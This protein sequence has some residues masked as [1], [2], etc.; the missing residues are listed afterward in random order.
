MS[1]DNSPWPWSIKECSTVVKL[2]W[3]SWTCFGQCRQPRTA[4]QTERHDVT[5][6]SNTTNTQVNINYMPLQLWIWSRLCSNAVHMHPETVQRYVLT[7]PWG[8][9]C[10]LPA[11]RVSSLV[12]STETSI[13]HIEKKT[14]LIILSHS[15][16]L[17]LQISFPRMFHHRLSLLLVAHVKGLYT[18]GDPPSS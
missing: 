14:I 17:F 13:T 16:D 18:E 15:L 9:R 7:T 2:D 1:G 11:C 3:R 5:Y 8:R 12:V 6:A 10:F 4:V